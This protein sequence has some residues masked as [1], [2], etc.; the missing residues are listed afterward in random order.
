MR[1]SLTWALSTGSNQDLVRQPWPFPCVCL[2]KKRFSN[3]GGKLLASSH[4]ILLTD[5]I[6][7]SK[8]DD[9]EV[10]AYETL[11][12]KLMDSAAPRFVPCK[13]L[14]IGLEERLPVDLDCVYH[15]T[16]TAEQVAADIVR[17]RDVASNKSLTILYRYPKNTFLHPFKI[18]GGGHPSLFAFFDPAREA[19][20]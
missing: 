14:G 20:F 18:D 7:N 15:A 10:L 1:S 12:K 3:S 13:R 4:P 2:K 5:C 11:V 6:Q 16:C 19:R 8:G 9:F 17:I